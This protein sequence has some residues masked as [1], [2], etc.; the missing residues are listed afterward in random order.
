MKIGFIAPEYPHTKIK[1]AAGLGTSIGNL[2]EALSQQGHTIYLF[3]YGQEQ[4]DYFVENSIHFYLIGDVSYG[5]GK[6]FRYRKHIQS[7]V[8]AVI[9]KEK[10]QLIEVPDWTGISAFMKFT[11]PIVMR[12]HGSDC[13]F[14]YLEGRKQKLKNKVFEQFAVR[15]ASAYITPTAFA[16]HVTKRLFNISNKKSIETI[17]HGLDLHSFKNTD[18]SLFDSKTI[19]Y[20]GTLIRK[21]GM[22]E[23]PEIFNLVKNRVPDAKL[24]LIGS[25]APDVLTRSASTWALMKQRFN[26]TALK[27]VQYL[28]RIPYSKV[29]T[30]IKNSQVCVFPTFA[31]T[32]GMVTVEAMA[33]QKPVVNSNIGWAQELMEDTVSG[34]LVSPAAH[35][36]YADKISKLLQDENL[37]LSMGKAARSFVEEHFDIKKQAIKNIEFYKKIIPL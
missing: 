6:W 31:E 26:K 2:V 24:L 16:G 34:Y 32:F 17:Y 15:G 11:V 20:I 5:V 29:Q 19:L 14:C 3:I 10:L 9:I 4:D 13:Y 23:L 22:L 18:P 12:F 8:Q 27:D 36:L 28:G 30:Y 33:L 7:V 25:D 1:Q 35:K 37:C 21:K